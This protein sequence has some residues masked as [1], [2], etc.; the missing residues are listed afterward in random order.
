MSE[1][2]PHIS[3]KEHNGAYLIN[4]DKNQAVIDR[5]KQLIPSNNRRFDPSLNNGWVIA[6]E[7][8]EIAC[9]ILESVFGGRIKRPAPIQNPFA[10]DVKT[11]LFRVEYVGSTHERPLHPLGLSKTYYSAYGAISSREWA[12]EFPEIVLK[13]FFGAIVEMGKPEHQTLYQ[14]LLIKENADIQAIKSAYRRMARQWHPDLCKESDA[15]DRFRAIDEAYKVLQDP[16]RRNKYDAGLY[17]ERQND[18]DVKRL[19][20]LNDISGY[21]APLTSGLITVRGTQSA[22]MTRFLVE[23]ILTWEDLRDTKDRVA[24]SSWRPGQETYQI[25]WR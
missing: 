7:S 19:D 6:P 12:I 24:I 21:R 5:F 8:I 10:G 11:E 1:R 15:V 22:F 13:R 23:E 2:R 3:I 20:L 25:V 16:I 9:Q 14:L 4:M 18:P 17:F